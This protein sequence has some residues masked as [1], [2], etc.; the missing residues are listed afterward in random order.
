MKILSNSKNSIKSALVW[1]FFTSLERKVEEEE[2][3]RSIKNYKEEKLSYKS[4]AE[5]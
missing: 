3:T 1:N 5:D 4:G 2:E